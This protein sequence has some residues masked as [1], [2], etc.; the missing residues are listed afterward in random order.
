[1]FYGLFDQFLKKLNSQYFTDSNWVLTLNSPVE[2]KMA[3]SEVP[4]ISDREVPGIS[5]LEKNYLKRRE[6]NESSRVKLLRDL[7]LN[8]GKQ[9]LLQRAIVVVAERKNTI[10]L[11]L[12]DLQ[13]AIAQPTE[14]MQLLIQMT[15]KAKRLAL[16][17][18]EQEKEENK[19]TDILLQVEQKICNL[20][21]A[22]QK[23]E[24]AVE[25]RRSQYEKQRSLLI[26]QYQRK[27]A[28]LLEKEKMAQENLLDI[29]QKR[30]RGKPSMQQLCPGDTCE[31][32]PSQEN[33]ILH[34]YSR[35]HKVSITLV[36]FL[37][38]IDSC[39][40]DTFYI[41]AQDDGSRVMFWRCQC[42]YHKE[43]R[44]VVPYE[45][46]D[47]CCGE[48]VQIMDLVEKHVPEFESQII[49][50]KEA[51]MNRL[52]GIYQRKLREF[53]REQLF[54]LTLN[55]LEGQIMRRR[56]RGA[57]LPEQFIQLQQMDAQQLVPDCPLCHVE[58]HAEGLCQPILNS[59]RHHNRYKLDRGN[60][61]FFDSWHL[62]RQCLSCQR[63]HCMTCQGEYHDDETPDP[64]LEQ[65]HVE[66]HNGIT[67]EMY[68]ALKRGE[69][70]SEILIR[71]STRDCPVCGAGIW[72]DGGCN[73]VSCRCGAHICWICLCDPEKEDGVAVMND[74]YDHI[75]AEH[76]GRLYD[77]VM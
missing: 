37:S 39:D 7:N 62:A 10:R 55:T 54:L 35:R 8:Q 26:E 12:Q 23:Q 68:R 44:R 69:D 6:N 15:T 76:R 59:D 60:G 27:Q 70:P 47:Y 25:K 21:K 22:Q 66:S 11:E 67:C 38:M 18:H 28:R 32:D 2:S 34:Y 74:V 42:R 57:R 58:N 53:E 17:L 56:Y 16:E 1:M 63:V 4:G 65:A 30:Q 13:T 3:D 64:Q 75:D 5:D 36:V 50:N 72:K 29:K 24:M 48:P 77:R 41:S 33:F 19:I 40:D 45:V 14:D 73:H 46:A 49:P 20:L 61:M 43:D 51:L 71:D 31:L 9:K 52:Q